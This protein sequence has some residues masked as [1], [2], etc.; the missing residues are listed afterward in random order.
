MQT[1]NKTPIRQLLT[2]LD[3]LIQSILHVLISEK[4]VDVCTRVLGDMLSARTIT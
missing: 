4:V 2:S 1:L 3:I